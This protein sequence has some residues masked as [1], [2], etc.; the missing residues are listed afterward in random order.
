MMTNRHSGVRGTG[1]RG[2]GE[3]RCNLA[4]EI[5]TVSI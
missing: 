4:A 5:C 2:G 3:V 1:G